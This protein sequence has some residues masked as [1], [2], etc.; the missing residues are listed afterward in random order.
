MSD[1]RPYAYKLNLQI[2]EQFYETYGGET[3]D[4]YRLYS[5]GRIIYKKGSYKRVISEFIRWSRKLDM[6][7]PIEEDEWESYVILSIDKC[8]YFRN[9]M[10]DLITA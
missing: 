5:N 8:I 4:V 7:F 9:K 10:Y 3:D 6:S 1:I 2:L